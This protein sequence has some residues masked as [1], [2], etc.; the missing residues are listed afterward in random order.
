[1]HRH[2]SH[3]P[4]AHPPTPVLQY[5]STSLAAAEAGEEPKAAERREESPAPQTQEDDA[6]AGD[7]KKK[8]AAAKGPKVGVWLWCESVHVRAGWVGLG[9]GGCGSLWWLWWSL[10]VQGGGRY[11]V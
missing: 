10:C 1:M 11:G 5:L 3:H 4:P 2:K 9:W 7:K 6:A 8:G